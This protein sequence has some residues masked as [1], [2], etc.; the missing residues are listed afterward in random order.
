MKFCIRIKNIPTSYILDFPSYLII[1]PFVTTGRPSQNRRPPPIYSHYT[2]NWFS[3]PP[4]TSPVEGLLI[5]WCS[6]FYG[7]CYVL[8]EKGGGMCRIELMGG[9]EGLMK[10]K[11]SNRRK[12]ELLRCSYYRL[13]SRS[14]RRGVPYYWTRKKMKR[15]ESARYSFAQTLLSNTVFKW[16]EASLKA[17]R[18]KIKSS[19]TE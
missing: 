19:K 2:P 5:Q 8:V 3:F 12:I 17:E 16:S 15:I 10:S 4:S 9:G 1:H 13:E 14:D 6:I 7:M 18:G 11:V